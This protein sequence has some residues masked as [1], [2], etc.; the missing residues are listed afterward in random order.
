MAMKQSTW[1]SLCYYNPFSERRFFV[2]KPLGQLA[3]SIALM[4]SCG[5]I[6]EFMCETPATKQVP[7]EFRNNLGTPNYL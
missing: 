4:R 2:Y 6:L 7:W 5:Y 3:A 1:W